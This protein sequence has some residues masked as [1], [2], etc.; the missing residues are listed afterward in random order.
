MAARLGRGVLVAGNLGALLW[1][2]HD[3]CWMPTSLPEYQINHPSILLF[4]ELKIN[5][6]YFEQNGTGKRC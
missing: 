5:D 1:D 4:N 2:L 6:A 3:C